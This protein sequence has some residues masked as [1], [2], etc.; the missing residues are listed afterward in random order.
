MQKIAFIV[1]FILCSGCT[2]NSVEKG[3]VS[4]LYTPGEEEIISWS[5]DQTIH[6]TTEKITYHTIWIDTHRNK[7]I[8][9]NLQKE[10]KRCEPSAVWDI[11]VC[12]DVLWYKHIYTIPWFHLKIDAYNNQTIDPINIEGAFNWIIENP[13]EITWNMIW[14]TQWYGEHEQFIKIYFY[15]SWETI[16]DVNKR[17][18]TKDIFPW[19]T[20]IWSWDINTWHNGIYIYKVKYTD[21][22]HSNQ[23]QMPYILQII[24]KPWEKYYYITHQEWW[25]NMHNIQYF[26]S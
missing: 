12:Y 6:H 25:L 13:F 10:W 3:I 18:N 1:I 26:T 2:N 15:G 9:M 5:I 11:Y 14:L 21:T 4:W 19:L 20:Y 7:D 22:D 24:S 17:Y 16:E 8:Y 23:K